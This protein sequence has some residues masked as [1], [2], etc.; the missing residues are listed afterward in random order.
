M[1]IFNDHFISV[2]H[3]GKHKKRSVYLCCH[4][5]E[6][7]PKFQN[8]ILLYDEA[9]TYSRDVTSSRDEC[10]DVVSS[11]SRKGNFPCNI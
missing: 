8:A 10:V 4:I 3:V 9:V 7:V 6:K 2:S 1:C 11:I 5:N